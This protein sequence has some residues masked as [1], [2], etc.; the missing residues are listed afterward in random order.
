[1][2]ESAL[3]LTTFNVHW[4]GRTPDGRATY[5][6]AAVAARLPGTVHAFQEV[7]EHPEEPAALP[8][9]AGWEVEELVLNPARIRPSTLRLPTA[10][11]GRAGR[12]T[13]R[14]ATAHP[15]IDR[16]DMPLPRV[17]RDGRRAALATRLATPLG[18][19]LVVSVH[20]VS[21]R[22]PFGPGRQVRALARQLPLGPAVVLGDHN[23]WAGLTGLLLRDFTLAARGATFPA[24]R[25]RHQIDHI[26]VRDLTVVTGAVLPP[27]GSDHLPVTATVR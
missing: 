23:L 10:A 21:R 6:L 19:L 12:L 25:P 7:W 3:T 8:V 15:V 20:L 9:P 17:G 13:M 4:G 1:V 24:P 18:D 14:L 27:V 22:I 16:W 5:D 26:W 11:A 2:H